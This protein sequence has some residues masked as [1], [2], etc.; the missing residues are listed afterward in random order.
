MRAAGSASDR[1]VTLGL[2]TGPSPDPAAGPDDAARSMRLVE[3]AVDAAGAGGAH[4][5]TYRVPERLSDLASGEAVLVMVRPGSWTRGST[6][7]TVPRK[8]RPDS[9]ATR[10]VTRWP[11]L[12]RSA[13]RS[14]T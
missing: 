11:T 2:E 5:Y 3:V 8:S 12:S 9:A 10:K 4:P 1:L 7:S 6:K 14:G 13:Y